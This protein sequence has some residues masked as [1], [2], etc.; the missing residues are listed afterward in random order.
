MLRFGDLKESRLWF[1]VLVDNETTVLPD[2]R[3][4]RD[5]SKA[6][7]FMRGNEG[8]RLVVQVK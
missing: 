8:S 4:F 6:E 5:R 2:G 1:V 3:V 7:R